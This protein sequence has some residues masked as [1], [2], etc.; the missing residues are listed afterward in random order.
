MHGDEGFTLA[1]DVR[2]RLGE[3]PVWSGADQALWFTDI[4]GCKLHRFEP[5][6][7]DHTVFP[8]AEEVGCL[9]FVKGGGFVVGARSGVW[10]LDG[11]GRRLRMLAANPED[12][13]RSRFN[14]G[15]ADPQGRFWLGTMHS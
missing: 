8:V 4:A 12:T 1:L 10:L 11:E 3:C 13:E 9:A 15:R 7:G 2:C 14:D 5:G 6:T